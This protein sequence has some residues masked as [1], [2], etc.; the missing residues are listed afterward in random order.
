[1][2]TGIARRFE[3]LEARSVGTPDELEAAITTFAA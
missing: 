2:L 3:G 1:V